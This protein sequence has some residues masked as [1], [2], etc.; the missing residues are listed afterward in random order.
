MKKIVVLMLMTT[1]MCAKVPLT[2]PDAIS[3]VK[4]NNTEIII[5]NFEKQIS[6][7]EHEATRHQHYGTVELS[8][9]ATRSNDALS[10]FGY[11]LQSRDATFA[12][13]GFKQFNGSNY[14]LAP[15]DLNHPKD[16][17]LFQTKIE[18]TLPLYTGGRLELYAN[19]T[20]A[21]HEMATLD[22]EALVQQKIF[23]LKKS[24]ATLSLLKQYDITLKRIDAN[25]AKL[26]AKAKALL[27]EGYIKKVDVLEVQSKRM[28]IERLI[29]MTTS[30]QILLYHYLSF[31]VNETV[32]D[33]EMSVDETIDV[34]TLLAKIQENNLELKKAQ[35]HV[36]I[37]KMQV[38]V[39]QSAFLPQVGAFVNYGSSDDVMWHDWA[40]NDAYTVGLSLKWNLFNG[41][42]DQDRLE[43]ARV[44]SL[45][46]SQEFIFAQKNIALRVQQL[47]VGISNDDIDIKRLIQEVVL[48][49]TIYAHY[50]GRYEQ[51][52]VSIHDVLQKQTEALMK[53]MKLHEA[54]N[55]R[56][57]K[58][59]ELQKLANKEAL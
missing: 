16:R 35:R 40:K 7:L 23:E 8:S 21:L 49:E 45:K 29:H 20:K 51:R 36:D 11:K 28:D 47:L 2:L 24:F 48:A 58:Q 32:E 43:K 53:T 17:N 25:M 13:F 39:A 44:Q 57:E 10:V 5:A 19:I 59:F 12:D 3:K 15:E 4:Q 37:S 1:F 46:A 41:G 22:H 14:L 6:F 52:L 33:V 42:S 38:G 31:L 27:E 56:Y 9:S 50:V 26:E 18:Y 34:P 30:Q 55:G 54:Y